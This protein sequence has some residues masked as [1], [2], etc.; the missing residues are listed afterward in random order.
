MPQ[1]YPASLRSQITNSSSAQ[2]PTRIE[3]VSTF[4]W[5]CNL[6]ISKT[7]IPRPSRIS[8]LVN[9]CK[10]MKAHNLSE[11]S[12]GNLL[13]IEVAKCPAEDDRNLTH[14]QK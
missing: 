2:K 1:L 3:T 9:L 13:W 6:G 7:W 11:Y 8:H 14:F 5:Q 12:I 10:R 4:I